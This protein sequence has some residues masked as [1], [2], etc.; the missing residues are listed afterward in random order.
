MN[1]TWAIPGLASAV[2]LAWS[3]WKIDRTRPVT[4]RSRRAAAL[5]VACAVTTGAY[6][7]MRVASEE[8]LD[9]MQW[10]S[11]SFFGLATIPLLT[12][13]L[14]GTYPSR[15]GSLA[16]SRAAHGVAA[17]VAAATV[18]LWVMDRD[19]FVADISRASSGI[20]QF[21]PAPGLLLV[22]VPLVLTSFYAVLV[23]AT[24]RSS[25]DRAEPGA[26]AGAI[27]FAMA[28]S[29]AVVHQLLLFAYAGSSLIESTAWALM[30]IGLPVLAALTLAFGLT[31]AVAAPQVRLGRDLARRVLT[32]GLTTIVLATLFFV[33]GETLERFLP[34][35]D[36]SLTILAAAGISLAMHPL[37][38]RSEAVVDRLLPAV[39]TGQKGE[40]AYL[41][42][43]EAAWSDGTLQYRDRVLL[44]G[45]RRQIGIDMRTARRL[46]GE[47]RRAV[48]EGRVNDP[49]A[50]LPTRPPRRRP[51]DRRAS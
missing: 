16:R 7:G 17:V 1:W 38:A 18:G 5:L 11:I 21:S 32:D 33:S 19:L 41:A 25:S 2:A 45:L 23:T 27:A 43:A 34:F 6:F 12:L 49:G 15:L 31:Q 14:L 46:E 22:Q 3:A 48:R 13:R 24:A 39:S 37:Q 50:R 8:P 51:T 42:A 9:A 30:D 44:D 28:G 29:A 26:R 47:A 35:E 40:R 10:T 4:G 20:W 36:T